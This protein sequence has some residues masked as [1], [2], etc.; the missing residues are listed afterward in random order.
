MISNQRYHIVT[1]IFWRRTIHRKAETTYDALLDIID[2]VVLAA[3]IRQGG[4][5]WPHWPRKRHTS[6]THVAATAIHIV[7]N[8]FSSQLLCIRKQIIATAN[9]ALKFRVNI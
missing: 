7:K 5:G 2:M 9:H 3:V 6:F 1:A 4:H 8:V